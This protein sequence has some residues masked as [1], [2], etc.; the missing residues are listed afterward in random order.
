MNNVWYTESWRNTVCFWTCPPYLKNVTTVPCEMQKISLSTAAPIGHVLRAWNCI[1]FFSPIKNCPMNLLVNFKKLCN[2]CCSS[3]QNVWC[4]LTSSYAHIPYHFQRFHNR[5]NSSIDNS[6][7]IRL[8]GCKN[9]LKHMSTQ[10]MVTFNNCCDVAYRKLKLPCDKTTGYLRTIHFF[11][12]RNACSIR[13]MNFAFHKVQWRHFSGVVDRFKNPYV[14]FLQDS[15]YQTLL[16]S[17]YF[18]WSYSKNKN[19]ATFLGHTVH[20][21]LTNRIET[22]Q[23]I[24]IAT[25]CAAYDNG[26][27]STVC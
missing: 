24:M 17:V 18:S 16:K 10:K 5:L 21:L 11:K 19:V 8:T 12:G 4:A 25:F 6:W 9:N 23:L 1:Y 7:T 13:C 15:V 14:E 20:S 2:I 27:L 22:S 3:N 26:C